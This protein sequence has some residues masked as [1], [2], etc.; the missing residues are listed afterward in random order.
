MTDDTGNYPQYSSKYLTSTYYIHCTIRG[1]F[2]KQK[3]SYHFQNQCQKSIHFSKFLYLLLKECRDTDISETCVLVILTR[4][5]TP[6]YNVMKNF[7]PMRG[8]CLRSEGETDQSETRILTLVIMYWLTNWVTVGYNEI[9]T[10]PQQKCILMENIFT[11][12][13]IIQ[14]K[15]HLCW[16]I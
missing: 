12:G 5:L 14:L 13:I 1:S 16:L 3:S 8:Q 4:G 11:L 15:S 2:I 6:A 10:A 9:Q 7:Q